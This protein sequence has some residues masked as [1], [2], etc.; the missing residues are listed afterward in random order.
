[1]SSE[2]EA[3]YLFHL[4][5]EIITSHR[6]TIIDDGIDAVELKEKRTETL[7]DYYCWNLE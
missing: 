2:I 1:M 4:L 3:R 5:E 6:E 7:Y